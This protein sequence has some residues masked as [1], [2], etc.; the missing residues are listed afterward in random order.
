[1]NTDTEGKSALASQEVKTDTDEFTQLLDRIH[2]V[3]KVESIHMIEGSSTEEVMLEFGNIAYPPL[4]DWAM[5]VET[6]TANFLAVPANANVSDI[7][8]AAGPISEITYSSQQLLD[9]RLPDAQRKMLKMISELSWINFFQVL[10][11][12]FLVP[13]QRIISSFSKDSLF[14][15]IELVKSLSEIHVENDVNPILQKDIALLIA[16]GDIV[17]KPSFQFAKAKLQYYIK[18]I[19]ALLPYKN[20]IRPIVLPGR[21]ATLIYIQRALLYGPLA[22]LIN[23]DSIPPGM[24]V[25]NPMKSVGNPSI[26]SLLEIITFTLSKYN[27]EKLSYNEQEI[28]DLIAIRD[29]KERVHVVAEFNKLTDDERAVELTNKKLGIGKWAVGGTKKI[30]AYDKEYYDQERQK[31]LAAGIVDFPGLGNGEMGEPEGR[32][33]DE[34]G[35]SVYDDQEFEKDGGYD[36]NQHGDDDNE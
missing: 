6:T 28:K 33:K 36:H 21:D 30:Y 14:V 3:N 31:R 15:P 18:Q 29:E 9:A 34:F 24:Q 17:N 20:K 27:V 10:Q 8:I 16:K 7:A 5:I 1:M 25:E 26:K 11:N 19:S 12:Y 13:F 35:F 23:P 22:T 32:E 4:P 2:T